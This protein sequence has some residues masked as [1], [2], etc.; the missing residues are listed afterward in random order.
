MFSGI[1]WN[2]PVYLSVHVSVCPSA[3][4]QN[5]D[6]FV[7]QTPPTVLLLLY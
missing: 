5:I 2:Q 3:H 4:V 7:L 6:N 1:N